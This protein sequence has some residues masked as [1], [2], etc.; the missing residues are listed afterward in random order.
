MAILESP[1]A[2]IAAEEGVIAK[3]VLMPGDPLRDCT[4]TSCITS[5]VWTPSSASAPPEASERM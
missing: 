2:C 5:T 4:P 3:A 1:S